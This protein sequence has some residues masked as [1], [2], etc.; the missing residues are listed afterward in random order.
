MAGDYKGEQI[1]I[2]AKLKKMY[3][4]KKEFLPIVWFLICFGFEVWA[5]VGRPPVQVDTRGVR[6]GRVCGCGC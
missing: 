5:T 4:K 2:R 1:D 6:R 3:L